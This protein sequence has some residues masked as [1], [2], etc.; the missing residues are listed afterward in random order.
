M[1]LQKLIVFGWVLA[2]VV[3]VFRLNVRLFHLTEGLPW[4]PIRRSHISR[5]LFDRKLA[6]TAW[7][8]GAIAGLLVAACSYLLPIL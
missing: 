3:V 6:A 5:A 4:L 2:W 1:S 8:E 7:V